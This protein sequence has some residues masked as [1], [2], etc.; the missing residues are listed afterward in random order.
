[1]PEPFPWN[2]CAAC[3]KPLIQT[4]DGDQERPYCAACN[5]FYYHN[6][7]PASCCFV[8]RGADELLFA[9][10]AVEPCKGQWTLPGGYVELGETT[11]EAALRELLEETNLRASKVQLLGVNTQQSKTTGSIVVFGY[12]IEDWEGE[13]EM[14]PNSDAM[15]LRFFSKTDRPPVPFSAHRELIAMYDALVS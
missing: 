11:E 8:R 3:G 2:Y 13:G 5:R 15:D 10:R 6:P 12:L 7:V 1:M 14:C 9:Q 4:L